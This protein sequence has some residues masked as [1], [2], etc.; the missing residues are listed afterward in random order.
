MKIVIVRHGKPDVPDF[1]KLK[2]CELNTWIDSYNAAGIVQKPPPV[3]TIE[4]ATQCRAV[5]CSDFPRSTQSAAALNVKVLHSASLFRE[6]CLPYAK[7]NL[8]RLSPYTWA[9]LF[10]IFWALG[11]SSHGESFRSF[12]LRASAGAEK[13]K[14]L[15]TEHGSVLFVGH[16][17]IN[18]FIAKEL[19]SSGWKGPRS[20]GWKHWAFGV[21]SYN[22]D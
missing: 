20:P 22:P 8:L 15:A 21:Y 12:Q 7:W 14:Q 13:L 5:V 11:Y 18:K 1:E 3:R 19:L 2:A 10:R 6:V 17:L 9:L 4:I 16:G